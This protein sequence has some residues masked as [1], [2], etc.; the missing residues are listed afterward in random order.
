MEQLETAFDFIHANKLDPSKS[1]VKDG[2]VRKWNLHSHITQTYHVIVYRVA[3]SHVCDLLI[4]LFNNL[5]LF[6]HCLSRCKKIKLFNFTF[7]IVRKIMSRG[8]Q[9]TYTSRCRVVQ[10][11]A[12][13]A[14]HRVRV[15]FQ[16]MAITYPGLIRSWS[17]G[18]R[19]IVFLSHT[20]QSGL[21]NYSVVHWALMHNLW[22]LNL[23]LVIKRCQKSLLC[24]MICSSITPIRSNHLYYYSS[25]M[26][27]TY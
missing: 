13:R 9:F 20:I 5:D 26:V 25:T 21:V 12:C 16:K 24:L 18:N 2:R 6:T 11:K 22:Q 10:S 17:I 8:F 7:A 23:Y 15:P 1:P 4:N 27:I 14:Q 3:Q 19:P